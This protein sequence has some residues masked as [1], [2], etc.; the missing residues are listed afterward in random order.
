[1]IN[2]FIELSILISVLI[3]IIIVSVLLN[4]RLFSKDEFETNL[5]V[6]D[7]VIDDYCEIIIKQKINYLKTQHVLD[8]SSKL[9]SIRLFN[10]KILAII[11]ESCSDI[12]KNMISKKLYKSLTKR[13]TTKSLSIYISARISHN[14]SI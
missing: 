2:L 5:M 13:F 1:M 11:G 8:S 14:I 4:K 12:M 10:N 6:L 3:F 9:N 7:R